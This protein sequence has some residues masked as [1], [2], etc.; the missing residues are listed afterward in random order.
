MN[1]LVAP[2]DFAT[3][4]ELALDVDRVIEILET[5]GFGGIP[6]R[7]KGTDALQQAIVETHNAGCRLNSDEI[8]LFNLR[9]VES[10]S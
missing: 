7:L 9:M 1:L 4:A 8:R 5:L 3:A 2:A 6:I 10:K